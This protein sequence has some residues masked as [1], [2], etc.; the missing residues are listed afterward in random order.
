M[1]PTRELDCHTWLAATETQEVLRERSFPPA[2]ELGS[3]FESWRCFQSLYHCPAMYSSEVSLMDPG[4]VP[5]KLFCRAAKSWLAAE[6][7]QH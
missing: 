2:T 7:Q 1:D 3:V 6:Q 4:H 5:A